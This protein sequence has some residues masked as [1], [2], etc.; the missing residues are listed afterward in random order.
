MNEARQLLG[1]AGYAFT[2]SS[3]FDLIIEYFI[4]NEKYDI[5]EINETLFAFDQKLLGE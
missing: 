1:R 2:E 4:E 3:K 5:F